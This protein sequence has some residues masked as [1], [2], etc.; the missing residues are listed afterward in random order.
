MRLGIHVSCPYHSTFEWGLSQ[1][2][3]PTPSPAPPPHS[4]IRPRHARQLRIHTRT[5]QSRVPAAIQEW[6]VDLVFRETS[7]GPPG[8]FASLTFERGYSNKTRSAVKTR[9]SRRCFLAFQVSRRRALRSLQGWTTGFAGWKRKEREKDIR[10]RRD[11]VQPLSGYW[12]KRS[13]T[14][15]TVS[16][17]QSW[18]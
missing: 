13:C 2:L 8:A 7:V 3:P 10:E 16:T 14:L 18:R 12:G 6:R 9:R 5:G 1:T 17:A 15:Q 4:P 11:E